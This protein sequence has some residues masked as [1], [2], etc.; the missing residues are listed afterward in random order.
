M[1]AEALIDETW[2]DGVRECV[3]PLL[4]GDA[5]DGLLDALGVL[6]VSVAGSSPVTLAIDLAAEYAALFRGLD[7]RWSRPTNASG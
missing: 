4:P 3:A 1:L 6:A 7:G 2:A 5:Q